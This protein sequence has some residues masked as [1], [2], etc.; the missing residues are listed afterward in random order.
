MT[1]KISWAKNQLSVTDCYL[2]KSIMTQTSEALSPKDKPCFRRYSALG[3]PQHPAY[4]YN[5]APLKPVK[6]LLNT[7]SFSIFNEQIN[8]IK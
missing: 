5:D 8:E 7:H 4:S 1:V 2:G 6:Q 3:V